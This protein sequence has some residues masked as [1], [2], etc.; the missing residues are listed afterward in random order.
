MGPNYFKTNCLCDAGATEERQ[1]AKTVKEEEK[2]H[3]SM[4]APS[5]KEE[6]SDELITQWK[7]ELKM[8]EDWLNNLEPEKDC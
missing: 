6:H 5:E 4:S 2:E 1:P 3:I 7:Q 8:L